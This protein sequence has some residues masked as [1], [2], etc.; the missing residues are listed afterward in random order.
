SSAISR[1]RVC[2]QD[3]SPSGR[4]PGQPHRSQSLLISMTP[5]PPT[6]HNPFAPCGVPTGT[7]SGGC[8]AV[9]QSPPLDQTA[10]SSPSPATRV[11][12]GAVSC[13]YSRW[14]CSV[15]MIRLGLGHGFSQHLARRQS[16]FPAIH[17][18]SAAHHSVV[19][20]RPHFWLDIQPIHADTRRAQEFDLASHR[21]IS[22]VYLDDLRRNTLFSKYFPQRF[23]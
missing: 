6:T 11:R 8:H 7:E 15:R 10:N 17:G 14:C 12:W 2:S 1:R 4:P 19:A 23:N 9:S 21:R 13:R 16:L 18:V 20:G 3:S 5:S 22:H